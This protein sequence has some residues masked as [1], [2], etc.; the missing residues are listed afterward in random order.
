MQ[1]FIIEEYTIQKFTT[2]NSEYK[3]RPELS[4][5]IIEKFGKELFDDQNKIRGVIIFSLDYFTEKFTDICESEKSVRFYQYVFWLHEQAAKLAYF[6][7]AEQFPEGINIKYLALY[8]RVLKVIL[9]QACE[10]EL[11]T[12]EYSKEQ[13]ESEVKTKLNDLLFLGEMMY[14]LVSYYAEQ[15][16]IDDA[17]E[18]IFDEDEEYIFQRKHH[19]G[20]IFSHISEKWGSHLYKTVVDENAM[21]D[22]Y[23]A[24]ECCFG[25]KYKD[26]GH[27]IAS[28][29]KELEPKG[30]E[31]VGFGWQTLTE[32]MKN[33]FNVDIE[34]AELFFKGLTLDKNNKMNISD[35]I[36]RPYKMNRYLYRPI[37]IWN[38][39]GSDYAILGKNAWTESIIQLATNAIPWG[40][41]P[42]EWKRKNNPK[43]KCFKQYIHQKEDEHDKWLD[44]ELE[45]RIKSLN[46]PY[47][48][49]VEYFKR[50]NG[51]TIS[52]NIPGIGEIDFIVISMELKTIFIIDCKHL[53]GRYDIANQK[54]DY[55][56]FFTNKKNYNN[57]LEQKVSWI[58][59][60]INIVNEHFSFHNESFDISDYKIEGIFVINTPTFYMFNNLQYRIYTVEE[61]NDVFTGTFKDPEF[62][63]VKDTEDEMVVMP[64]KYPFF[65][66]PKYKLI[67][68]FDD[69]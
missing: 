30:G 16:M 2:K 42:E 23:D 13:I 51:G 9:E 8:R 67:D 58:K 25:I 66:K 47:Y 36:I 56:A 7:K 17:V 1:T 52:I 62:T 45:T 12:I 48:R 5:L 57:Q 3:F 26:V 63:I 24:F 14:S 21:T 43:T 49:T 15:D 10:I 22:M 27:L 55:N 39:D 37:L 11:Q 68:F 28:I 20:Q 40:K 4:K 32:N 6:G 50:I 54:N 34:T 29:H 46:I 31:I 61:V 59:E 41:V 19:Y 35:L 38:I 60:N 44:N 53:L 64:V 33:L 65:Q 18:I 69:F